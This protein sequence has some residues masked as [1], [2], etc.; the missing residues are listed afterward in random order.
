[1]P[2]YGPLRMQQQ[3]LTNI[4]F[5]AARPSGHSPNPCACAGATIR[6]SWF[7]THP[8]TP[9]AAC[10]VR[11]NNGK[12][13]DPEMCAAARVCAQR[14]LLCLR[15]SLLARLQASRLAKSEP[16][17]WSSRMW[18]MCKRCG[19]RAWTS[20]QRLSE[21]L[22]RRRHGVGR[23]RF[24]STSARSARRVWAAACFPT[25]NESGDGWAHI[26]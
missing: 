4:T 14:Q 22:Q 6:T 8:V 5:V 13:L 9:E 11:S 24:A 7:A 21:S 26:V 3:T 20:C 25:H 12:G 23:A 2:M 17:D 18:S 19:P 15:L 10:L 16:P 1:V